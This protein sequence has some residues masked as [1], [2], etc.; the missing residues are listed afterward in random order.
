MGV[1]YSFE[2]IEKKYGQKGTDYVVEKHQERQIYE[3]INDEIVRLNDHANLKQKEDTEFIYQ[4][5][6]RLEQTFN[7]AKN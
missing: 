3:R 4:E 5:K 6:R 7:D 2:A 1:S